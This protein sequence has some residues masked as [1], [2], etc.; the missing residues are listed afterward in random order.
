MTTSWFKI[1]ET[2]RLKIGER[3]VDEILVRGE[4]QKAFLKEAS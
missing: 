3:M 4:S 2:R 1:R